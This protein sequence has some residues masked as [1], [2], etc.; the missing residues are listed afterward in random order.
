[1]KAKLPI[2]ARIRKLHCTLRCIASTV[3][4]DVGAEFTA[5]M[6]LDPV[7]GIITYGSLQRVSIREEAT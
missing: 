5:E 6:R 2:H 1:M 3:P 4:G 7:K